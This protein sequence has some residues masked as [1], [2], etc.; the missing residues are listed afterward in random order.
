MNKR[1]FVMLLAVFLVIALAG[2][3]VIKTIWL[4][5][6]SDDYRKNIRDVS[7]SYIAEEEIT[8][9]MASLNQ[10][11]EKVALIQGSTSSG[12]QIAL[13]FDGLTDRVVM[14]QVLDLLEKYKARATFFVD[15]MGTAEDPQTVFNIREK[16]QQIG[17]YTLY[18]LPKMETMAPEKLV[19][20]FVR[21]Q[22]IIKV[23]SDQG[24]GLLKCNDTTYTDGLRQVAKA[25]GFA[26][27]V[28]SGIYVDM[29][30]L[31]RSAT[32]DDF[33]SRLTPGIIVSIKLK[34]NIDQIVYEPGKTDDRP[35]VD[36][37][38]GLKELAKP[39]SEP[40]QNVADAVEKLLI[41]L[42]KAR[43]TTVYV[44]TFPKTAQGETLS[45]AA[46]FRRLGVLAWNELASLFT[47]RTAAAAAQSN[48]MTQ[49]RTTEPALA[50]TFGGLANRAAVDDLLSRLAAMKIRGTF[51]VAENEMRRYP[52]TI[53]QVMAGG[54]ELG[55][56]IRPK[57]NEAFDETRNTIQ[58]SQAL[59]LSYFGI[60]TSLL[61][62]VGGAVTATTKGAADSLGCI[63]IGQS[64]NIVQS[65]HKD[66]VSAE[67]VMGEIFGKGVLS[68]ARGHILYFRL[69][70]YTNHRLA[71]D[72]VER[73]KQRKVDNIAY[74]TSID[75]PASN[76][77][78][79]SQYVIK[80]VGEI[81]GNRG[82]TYQYPVRGDAVLPHLRLEATRPVTDSKNFIAETSK[83]YIGHPDVNT[84]DRML[85]FSK[86]EARRLDTTGLIHTDRNEIF[87]TF[88]DWGTDAAINKL[89]YVLRKHDV[90]ATFFIITGNVLANANLLRSIAVE[91]HEIGSHSDTHRAMAV[92][93]PNTNKQ[94]RTL[95]KEEY[96]ADFTRGYQKLL[97]VTG[98]ITVNGRP[99]LTRIF[100][101]ATLA[102]S[103]EGFEAVFE[104][105]FEYIINGS[106]STY[107]Y[108]AQ[109]AAELVHNFKNGIYTPSGE[110]K[111]GS[112][113]IMH[114]SD[115]SLFTAIALDILL[116]ANAAK[117]NNDPTKF[118]VG[119]LSDYLRDGY[120]QLD[121]KQAIKAL[122]R[123]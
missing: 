23:N 94:V 2:A 49:I 81:L 6:P 4:A 5:K 91:G 19:R 115:T 33:V 22:K 90:P 109:T 34:R 11:P 51:F 24:P 111:K 88:D 105:G 61:K 1:I 58:R 46:A 60:E 27:L 116:T 92:R 54:H 13:T 26:A 59:L 122:G 80:P 31:N 72:L 119:R 87:L 28:R 66:I 42:E 104:A 50:F 71:G 3:Y 98:D 15:G 117:A 35:A 47:V 77:G 73:I 36:K 121:R 10:K 97:D 14:Q 38:P 113:L 53:R 62:Q 75:N 70:F 48:E 108:K 118:T 44:E 25:C 52:D 8:Q 17:N 123:Q 84:E 89:L 21:A 55:I 12:R 64:L 101:P 29:G 65:K 9:A 95:T 67:V 82:Y 30:Q 120:S 40:D 103:K 69:D 57:D 43:Y 83:R 85:G 112:V 93:D 41:S 16:G 79:N 78:N 86:M 107:D 114:C 39:D 76:R 102:I 110:L 37:Q 99:A 56:A 74:A 100:R 45:P 32:A 106:L 63:L 20:D 7:A 68:L 18:G 96:V